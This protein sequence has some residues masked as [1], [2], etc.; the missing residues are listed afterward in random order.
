[1]PVCLP[2]LRGKR[3]AALTLSLVVGALATVAAH[4]ITPY[5]TL[6]YTGVVSQTNQFTCG[7][8]SLATLLTYFYGQPATETEMLQLALAA[9]PQYKEGFTL[10]TLKQ[11]L[12]SRGLESKGYRLTPA[13]LAD[14][15]A[16]G[17][18]PVLLHGTKPSLHYLIAVG[19]AGDYILLRDPAWGESI[20][21]IDE[22]VTVKGFAGTVLIPLPEPEKAGVAAE[23][24]RLA[25]AGARRRLLRLYRS[26]GGLH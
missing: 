21:A 2:Q 3:V 17:G 25:L 8:A 13:Q 14:Y 18:L 19:T 15:F 23:N 6:R 12:K 16:Q 22:L 5:R 24:Q 7:P 9:E 10:L 4:D 20:M 1:M 11:I 26:G